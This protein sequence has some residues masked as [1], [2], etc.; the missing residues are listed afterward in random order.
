MLNELINKIKEKAESFS[1]LYVEDERQLREQMSAFLGKIFQ[2]VDMA[3]NGKEGLEKYLKNSYDIVITDIQM[4]KMN[5]LELIQNIRK[6]NPEQ[7]IIV[8]SAYAES[9]YLM[10]AIKSGVTGYIIKPI[11]FEQILKVLQQSIDKLTAFRENEVYKTKLE[12]IVEERTKKVVNLQDELVSNYKQM[13][14]SFVKMVEG[15]DAYTAGHSERVALY[16][17]SIAKAMG[18]EEKECDLIYQAGILHDIGKI[19]TPDTIL[20]KPGKL[21][22]EEYLLIKEHVTTSYLILSNVPMYKELANIVYC[23]HERYDGSGY[24]RALKGEEILL[25]GRIMSVADSFDAMTTSRIYKGR[26][27][28]DEAVKELQKLSGIYYDPKVVE[29][30]VNILS[31]LHVDQTVHQDPNTYLD[32]ARFAYFYKDTLTH[33]YNHNYLDFVLIKN[34]HENKLICLHVI[35]IRRFTTYNK[36]HGWYLGDK[37][38]NEFAIYLKDE[39]YDSQIFRIFGDDFA[40]LKH[41]HQDIDIDKINAINML[42]NNNLYCEHKHLDLKDKYIESYKDLERL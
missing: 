10:Q 11:D 4:P 21:T 19:I 8:I 37:L 42:K 40:I 29:I 22:N 28:V 2:H 12:V 3:V 18:F 34:K 30:A 38:L 25:F 36:K 20:L 35:Y 14:L 7:E 16:S 31:S 15:R 17:K 6:N 1:I 41:N 39:F 13:M 24:P 9:E 27:T 23:H 33:L 32:D 26:K 5:G